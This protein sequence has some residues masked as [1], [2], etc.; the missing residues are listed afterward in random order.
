[1]PAGDVAAAGVSGGPEIALVVQRYGA[2]VAG[3]SESLARALAERLAADHRVSV[4]TSCARDYVTW[5]NEMPE[6][7]ER[8]G[9]VLVR[10]FKSEEERD[11]A[12]FNALSD[13]L[14]DKPHSPQQEL[15]WLRR[16]GPFV[17][18]LVQALAAERDRFA[19]VLFFTYLY[20]PTYWGLRA[21]P[22]RAILVPTAHDEPALRLGIY[23]ELFA[24]PRA[25]A[26][27]TPPEAE[28]VRSRFGIGDRPESVAGI[29]I[30]AAPPPDVEAFRI[31]HDVRGPYAL[32]AGRV[33]AG[34]GC[35]ELVEFHDR[36]RRRCRGGAQLLL[37][38][39]LAM[40]EPR[41]PG[42]RY[43]GYL[44]EA[45]KR[46]ALAGAAV[47]VCPSPFESLSILL[48]EAMSLGVPVLANARSPVLLDHC[49]RSQA[50]LYY[51][52]ADEFVEALALLVEVPELARGLGEN[53]R[54]Y[55]DAEYRWD[56]VLGRY[57]S[58][59]AAVG[60]AR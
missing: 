43:L 60:A 19:A 33:D 6:G 48:L 55:V 54:R 42:V 12:S 35:A 24:L 51:A 40:P 38:G 13:A 27:L 39:R 4:F 45:E 5:R 52:E 50:G 25:F 49:R 37:I 58:L 46:A 53:G 47:V 23:Q 18:R 14:F 44:D 22:E 21:A 59:I 30:D 15:D 56:A 32:Y 16:Q 31:R 1:M 9:G 7:E 11:L 10:R 28:L 41:A 57:R 2:D 36:Y 8:L 26:F 17:P 3:G 34:K 29:G 20:Y